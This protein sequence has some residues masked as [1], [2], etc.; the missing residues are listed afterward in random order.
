MSLSPAFI[1]DVAFAGKT[2]FYRDK[3]KGAVPGLILAVQAKGKVWKYQTTTKDGRTTRV[4]L[5]PVEAYSLDAARAFAAAQRVKVRAGGAL[6]ARP[7]GLPTDRVP[8]LGEAMAL[9]LDY[10]RRSGA[11]DSTVEHVTT[12]F[13]PRFLG[14]WADRPVSSITKAEC[15]ARHL[16]ITTS[17]GPVTADRVFQ[18]LRAAI[19]RAARLSEIS[20]GNPAQ[21]VDFNNQRPTMRSVPFA[22]VPSLWAEI[23]ALSNPSRRLYQ[24]L[25]FLGGTRPSTLKR[26]K[27]SFIRL[28]DR[29]VDFPA[30]VMKVRTAWTL[31]LSDPMAEALGAAMTLHPK[32]E[33]VF[34]TVVAHREKNLSF[35]GYR[36]RRL[37]RTVCTDVELPPEVSSHLLSHAVVST[38]KHYIDFEAL[39]PK[40]LAAQGKVSARLLVLARAG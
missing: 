17:S 8:T 29:R 38:A 18:S 9:Y 12:H 21:A 14:R 16:E 15:A 1:A 11:A 36:L 23:N 31:P 35:Y 10:L 32:S 28:N 33:L 13:T 3:G 26:M 39:F 2:K 4:T 22:E 34:P 27:R 30:E 25:L 6:H 5:G 37:Y 20:F 24:T 19:N 7:A 40:L